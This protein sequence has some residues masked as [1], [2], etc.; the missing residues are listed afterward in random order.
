MHDN[1]QLVGVDAVRRDDELIES[2][3]FGQYPEPENTLAAA[4]A[5]WRD[6]VQR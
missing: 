2:L 6:E 5:A 3:R 4:L 1:D